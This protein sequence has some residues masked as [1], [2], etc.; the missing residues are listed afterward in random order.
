MLFT[1]PSSSIF[2]N[3]FS[4]VDRGLPLPLLPLTFPS[5]IFFAIYFIYIFAT[6]SFDV[7]YFLII[8]FLISYPF[9]Y[10][11]YKEKLKTFLFLIHSTIS[12]IKKNLKLGLLALLYEK[13]KMDIKFDFIVHLNQLP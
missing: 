12:T 2:Y 7:S 8:L 5:Y 1:L 6:H 9:Y 13:K 11:Y 3:V 4:K 10:I